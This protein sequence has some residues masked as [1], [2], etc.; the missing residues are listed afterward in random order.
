MQLLQGMRFPPS[1]IITDCCRMTEELGLDIG[2]RYVRN[3]LIVI[4]GVLTVR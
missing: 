4:K 3:L 1:W 2:T